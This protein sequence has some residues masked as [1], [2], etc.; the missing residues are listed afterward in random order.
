MAGVSILPVLHDL[1][2]PLSKETAVYP[3]DKTPEF[4]RRDHGQYVVTDLFISTH[5]GTHIDAPAHYFQGGLTID[6]IPLERLIGPC[7]VLDLSG[8][9]GFIS[10]RELRGK[11]GDAE[12]VLLKTWY[13]GIKIFDPSYPGLDGTTAEFLAENRIACI[14]IDSPSI[15]PFGGDGAVHRQLLSTG[16]VII[17]FLDLT[18]VREGDYYMAALPLRLEG[19]DGSPARVVLLDREEIDSNGYHKVRS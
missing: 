14:G 1:T 10:S 5:S 7:R 17:E 13:S 16:T 6:R 8:V 11:I 3:G 2:R 15:E 19:L 4:I 9:H 18:G 12:R